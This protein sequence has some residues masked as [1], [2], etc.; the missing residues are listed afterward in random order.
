MQPTRLTATLT[1][2]AVMALAVPVATQAQD[3][4]AP[5]KVPGTET[6]PLRV[7]ARAKS[8]IHAE[9]NK[10]ADVV[11]A[12]LGTFAMY[13][14]YDAKGAGQDMTAPDG[15]F[16]VGEDRR[17][18]NIV[19]WIST[20]DALVWKHGMVATFTAR[21]GRAPVM[22]VGQRDP[23]EALAKQ[24]EADRLTA[25]ADAYASI[26][27]KQIPESLPV[28]AIEPSGDVDELKHFYLMPV[29][30][31][32]RVRMDGMLSAEEGGSEALL[33]QVAT[34]IGG[35]NREDVLDETLVDA[36]NSD[37]VSEDIGA[38]DEALS[39]GDARRAE[40]VKVDVVF[41]V[42][43]TSSMKP[44][45]ARTLQAVSDMADRIAQDPEVSE[46]IKFGLW[47]YRDRDDTPG[48]GFH[49]KNFTP[50]ALQKVDS[51]QETLATADVDQAMHD[52]PED[53]FTALDKALKETAW[54]G[55][56]V[57]DDDR[58][59]RFVILIGDAPGHTRTE[60]PDDV[61]LG[62]NQSGQTTESLRELA[63]ANK[64][65]VMAIH[66]LGKHP[67]IHDETRRQFKE[68]TAAEAL[69]G[70]SAY[71]EIDHADE[72]AFQ[73]GTTALTTQLIAIVKPDLAEPEA[74]SDGAGDGETP[75]E[76]AI[77]MQGEG[78]GDAGEDG[79]DAP[80]EEPT[81]Q[82]GLA[83]TERPLDDE[84]RDDPAAIG[85]AMAN[86]ALM[87]WLGSE[88]TAPADVT[89]WTLDRDLIDPDIHALRVSIFVTKDQ[90]DNMARKLNAVLDSARQA[91]VSG[92]TLQDTLRA[93]AI[94]LSVDPEQLARA[95]KIGGLMDEWIAILPKQTR[96]MVMSSEEFD[97]MDPDQ[98]DAFLNNIEGKIRFYEAVLESPDDWVLLN[99][100][101]DAG[102][103][104]YPLPFAM[105]P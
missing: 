30:D 97:A 100:G 103:R 14:V 101:D 105:L 54:T 64:A 25:S 6:L 10:D 38:L 82:G 91:Q 58:S 34:A 21:E 40:Q 4:R 96:L 8:T 55:E 104:V 73:D 94:G 102:E 98:Q 83:A 48:I 13:Y 60:K 24:G 9:P 70:D 2:A 19:G 71:W 89:G 81:L 22:I 78:G 16:E 20:R 15:W 26:E 1:L 45:I 75:A 86:A 92:E 33:L 23:L 18:Q 67:H 28:R 65:Y 37:D 35:S 80:A 68:L 50:D 36:R 74:A 77:D 57:S 85:T 87:E 84:D 17:G 7:L 49:T 39:A 3:R 52:L 32:K 61:R 11:A 12:N 31:F 5:M 66:V 72:Q 69:R 27:Q 29:L 53:M 79:G 88:A 76:D 93:N 42:D 63:A 90:L 46:R 44:Y 43:M 56:G 99:R 95:E 59:L 62:Y 47:G 41:V 51:F